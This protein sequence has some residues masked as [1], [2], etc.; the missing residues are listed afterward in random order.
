LQKLF[1]YLLGE[2]VCAQE[3]VVFQGELD[4]HL[5]HLLSDGEV[6]SADDHDQVNIGAR[7]GFRFCSLTVFCP[8]K[9]IYTSLFLNSGD[10]WRG[11]KDAR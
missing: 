9:G 11:A 3:Q 7:I 10:H 6:G 5:M 2:E 8:R 4:D 1:P